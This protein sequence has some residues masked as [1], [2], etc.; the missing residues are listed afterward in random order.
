VAQPKVQEGSFL[1]CPLVGVRRGEEKRES[2]G[3]GVSARAR[4]RGCQGGG[5]M[6]GEGSTV[7]GW[8]YKSEGK[9]EGRAHA[10]SCHP[11]PVGVL[12]SM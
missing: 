7:T 6:C 12:L 11:C 4:C 1:C 8:S 10:A 2:G 9:R 5:V 3:H